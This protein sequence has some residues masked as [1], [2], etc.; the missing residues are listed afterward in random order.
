MK[1]F[2][3]SL[4]AIFVISTLCA[5]SAPK[6]SPVAVNGHLRVEGTQLVN[7]KGQPLTLRGAS[8]GWHNIWPRFYNKKAV[9][10]IASDW[11]CSV[12]RAAMGLAIEDNYLENP[13]FALQCVTNV[14][15]GAIK[16]GVYVIIDFHSHKMHT[17]EAVKFFELMAGRYKDCPNV[18]YEIWNEPD[19]YTWPEVKEYSER[20]I[21][22]IRA[23]DKDNIILVGSPHW[24]QD[25]DAVAA[26]P[27]KGQ[28][29]IMYTMHFYAGTHKQW[30]RDR[31][32]AAIEKGIP[33]FVSECAGMEASGN[34][35]IDEAE[36]KAFIDWMENRKISW[37]VWSISDKDETCSMIIPRAASTGNWTDDLLKKWGKI[38]RQ[39]IRERQ[40]K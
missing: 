5:F 18:I 4:P 8:F 20:V 15:E 13:E 30:L 3:N 39:T 10:W 24:D 27:I 33:V 25:L 26:D 35:P 9:A 28:A 16:N 11:Q 23:I 1:I 37:V 32:D 31:T 19:Y 40:G 21:G 22:A 2:R 38:T 14:V 7:E 12:V 6:N 17:E 36:W 34:G 29:N